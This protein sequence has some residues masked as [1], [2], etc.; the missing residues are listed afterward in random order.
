MTESLLRDRFGRAATKLRVS[1][2]DR[3]NLRCRYCMPAEGLNWQ[4]TPEILTQPE[5]LRLLQLFRALGIRQVRLTGGEPLLRAD[6]AELVAALQPLQF[7]KI[8]LTTNGVLLPARMPALYRAGLRSLNLSLDSLIAERFATLTRRDQAPAVMA[9]LEHLKHYPDLEIKLNVV[10]LRGLNDDEG[11]AFARLARAT[12][13]SVR[14]IEFMPLGKDDGWQPGEVV[15]G[16]EICAAIEAEYPLERVSK[17]GL[18]PAARWRFRDGQPGEIGLINSVSEPFCHSCNRIRLTADGQLR[19]CLFS[20]QECDLKTP[21]R[22]GASEQDLQ[23][24][25]LNWVLQKERGH[26]ISQPGFE[27]PERSMSQIGG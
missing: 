21:L 20:R 5:I 15:S 11:P 16:R 13:W 18:E 22:A 8:S 24:L 12:G 23:R 1:L 2:T 3:C 9:A 4:P 17:A 26:Q 25:I 14:F 7:E 6:L 10:L 19:N 27:R